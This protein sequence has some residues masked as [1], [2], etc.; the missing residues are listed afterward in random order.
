MIDETHKTVKNIKRENILTMPLEKLCVKDWFNRCTS[1]HRC[2]KKPLNINKRG[3]VLM[4][5]AN[6]VSQLRRVENLTLASLT[7]P[8]EIID[9]TSVL[10]PMNLE[11]PRN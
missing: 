4:Q 7:Y 11:F 10:A 1:Y 2:E 8:R 5:M 6:E 3:V 9:F